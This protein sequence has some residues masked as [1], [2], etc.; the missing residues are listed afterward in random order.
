MGN[1]ANKTAQTAAT[2]MAD[3]TIEIVCWGIGCNT[4]I[5]GKYPPIKVPDR[6]RN[7]TL[8]E[9]VILASKG[10]T[11]PWN[12][13]SY[14]IQCTNKTFTL[15][16]Q[17]EDATKLMMTVAEVIEQHGPIKMIMLSGYMRG[18]SHLTGSTMLESIR[19]LAKTEN[20]K[21][22]KG[23]SE[24]KDTEA[25]NDDT[26][27][28]LGEVSFD[29]IDGDTSTLRLFFFEWK[30]DGVSTTSS[31]VLSWFAGGHCL[32]KSVSSLRFDPDNM[33][34][35]CP[36]PILP[37]PFTNGQV[38]NTLVAVLKPGTDTDEL[39]RRISMLLSESN[40]SHHRTLLLLHA[41]FDPCD[42]LVHTG[43][44]VTLDGFSGGESGFTVLD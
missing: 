22:V 7:T 19:I 43:A 3:D 10:K 44:K 15:K 12:C 34:L 32:I 29:D 33:T 13:Y 27:L 2:Q 17:P 6:G 24:T 41:D 38:W 23:M 4:R 28:I 8:D 42:D 25:A 31:T 5:N 40:P 26:A 36:Q 14:I 20:S 21:D 35:T 16:G 39:L 9:L 18:A 37:T 1:K 30:K 11:A